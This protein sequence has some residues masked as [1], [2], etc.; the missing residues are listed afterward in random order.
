VVSF[1]LVCASCTSLTH[2]HDVSPLLLGPLIRG[3]VSTVG[4]INLRFLVDLFGVEILLNFSQVSDW[5]YVIQ[6][7]IRV[8]A[9]SLARETTHFF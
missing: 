1:C 5:K 6:P 7:L 8:S 3:S 4:P 9:S 2:D